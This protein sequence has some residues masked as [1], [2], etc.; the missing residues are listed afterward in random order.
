MWFFE[1]A[2]LQACGQSALTERDVSPAGVPKAQIHFVYLVLPW[3]QSTIS[4]DNLMSAFL[5]LKP[6]E[7]LLLGREDRAAHCCES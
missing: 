7:G 5:C 6:V 3:L 1:L 4:F 2:G